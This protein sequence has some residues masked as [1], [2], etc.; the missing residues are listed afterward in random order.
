MTT[1]SSRGPF[2]DSCSCAPSVSVS[3][4]FRFACRAWRCAV[5]QPPCATALVLCVLCRVVCSVRSESLASE[6]IC[7]IGI[8]RVWAL[9]TC[10][11]A[12]IVRVWALWTCS[13][14]VVSVPLP[15]ALLAVPGGVLC[16]SPHVLQPLRFA[17]RV[18]SCAPWGVRALRQS[19]F[20]TLA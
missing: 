12:G 5:L 7:Y 10:S 16:Y 18:V 17:C 14:A 6:Y 4:A 9:W 2:W 1:F 20:A 19:T 8:V 13:L 15:F 11:L 3:L